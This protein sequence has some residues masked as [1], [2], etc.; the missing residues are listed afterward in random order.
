MTENREDS[1]RISRR[2]LLKSVTAAGIGAVGL[3]KVGGE[4]SPNG[5]GFAL[6]TDTYPSGWYQTAGA[7]GTG[8]VQLC[9]NEIRFRMYSVYGVSKSGTPNITQLKVVGIELSR[10]ENCYLHES[11]PVCSNGATEWYKQR[12][13]TR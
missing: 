7:I 8:T 2:R 6:V 3:P 10:S 4:T 13:S 11:H 1:D 12:I 9:G 5:S